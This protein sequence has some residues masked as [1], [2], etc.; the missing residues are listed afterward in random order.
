MLGQ[1]GAADS[2][3]LTKL[4]VQ[5]WQTESRIFTVDS[6]QPAR[7]RIRLFYYPGWHVWVNGSEIKEVER[8]AHDAVVVRIPSGHSHVL[9]VF[10]NTP[11]ET[12]GMIISGL[13]AVLVADLALPQ[14]NR[15][16]RH[17][18]AV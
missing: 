2:V 3:N 7:V 15:Q 17:M 6:S 16:R 14:V 18:T 5:S 10:K 11:D 9:L 12:W 8:D 13:V 1:G 4:A